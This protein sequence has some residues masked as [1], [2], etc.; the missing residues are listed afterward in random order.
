VYS[1]AGAEVLVYP[2]AIGGE[3]H[4][5]QLDTE[6]LWRQMISTNGLANATFMVVVNRIGEEHGLKFY[7][8]SFVSDPYGRVIAQA[9]RDQPAVLIVELDLEQ[10]RDWL[11]FGLLH[12][13]RPELYR[14]LTEPSLVEAH[15]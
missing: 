10:R 3:P 15:G 1:L 7:G 14:P 5:G 9:P 6:P 11:T 2:T 12:T 4:L 8:S 13:R